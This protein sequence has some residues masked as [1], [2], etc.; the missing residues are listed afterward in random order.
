MSQDKTNH[1]ESLL[2]G[3]QNIMQKVC[4]CV[5]AGKSGAEITEMMD[6]LSLHVNSDQCEIQCGLLLFISPTLHYKITQ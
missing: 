6:G 2:A 3:H 4:K 5:I 1:S